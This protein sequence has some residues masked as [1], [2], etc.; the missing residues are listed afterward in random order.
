MGTHSRCWR[1]QNI[2]A[3]IGTWQ[4]VAHLRFHITLYIGAFAFI[5]IITLTGLLIFH[6]ARRTISVNRR[7]MK[8]KVLQIVFLRRIRGN[9]FKIYWS[10]VVVEASVVVVVAFSVEETH[11]L[12]SSANVNPSLHLQTYESSVGTHFCEHKFSNFVQISAIFE[13]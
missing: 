5:N 3:L 10:L 12:L 13:I 6:I 11:V 7:I 9:F 8:I 4:I 2:Q 1:W